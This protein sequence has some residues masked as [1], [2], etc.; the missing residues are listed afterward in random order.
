[1]CVSI[2]FACLCTTCL[3][4]ACRGQKR[5]S[6]DLELQTVIK[7]SCGCL[8][9]NCGPLEK[10]AVLLTSKPYLQPPGTV[11]LIRVL[12]FRSMVGKNLVLSWTPGYQEDVEQ[13]SLL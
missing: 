5:G 7:W 1:M 13:G 4:G 6:L 11:I 10:Q 2:M 9:L 12:A 3:A 8:E